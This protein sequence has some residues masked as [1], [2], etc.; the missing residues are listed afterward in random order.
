MSKMKASSS[1]QNRVAITNQSRIYELF[2][3]DE[4]LTVKEVTE[5]LFEKARI[6]DDVTLKLTERTVRRTLDILV[7]NGFIK[8]FGK[9][10]NAQTY[11]KISASYET[12]NMK[13]INLGGN[14][15]TVEDFLRLVVDPE[16]KPLQRGK[17]AMVSDQ[18]EHAIQRRLAFVVLTAGNPGMNEKLKQTNGEL[19]RFLKELNF[20]VNVLQTF[21]DSPVW[22]EQYRDQIGYQLRSVQKNDP[23]LFQLA[24]EYSRGG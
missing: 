21:V 19:H 15:Y 20:T 5:R 7:E 23:D 22:Y 9:D 6:S 3:D 2:G 11:G 24:V 1:N 8:P 4:K 18:I 10:G 17:V 16:N 12:E 13:L 14:L